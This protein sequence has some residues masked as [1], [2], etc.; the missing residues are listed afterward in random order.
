MKKILWLVSV[1]IVLCSGNAQSLTLD[2]TKKDAS[3][4]TINYNNQVKS[5]MNLAS[6]DHEK[7]LA[8]FGLIAATNNLQ[9]KQLA[10]ENF[11][12]DMTKY[13]FLTGDS[14]DTVNPKLW[15]HAKINMNI[16][17][18]K[19]TEN[20]YQVRGFDIANITFIIG[21]S[22][23]IIIDPLTAQETA[24]AALDFVNEKLGARPVAAVI[25][26]HSHTDHYGGINGVATA[27]TKIYAPDGFMDAVC[28]ENLFAGV[29]MLR[30]TFF[31]YGTILERGI[32]GH[33]DS[34]LGK[35][36]AV[37]K[38]SLRA[39]DFI[40]TNYM[41]TSQVD[42]V[43]M[44][45]QLTLGT[46]APSEMNVYIPS[47]K[48]LCIAEN[49][50]ATLHNLYTLRGAEVRDPEKW[51]HYL[52]EAIKYFGHEATSI[53]STHNWPRFGNSEVVSFMQ[54]Q[55][56]CY[57]YIKDQTLRLMSLGYT[58]N[59]VGR[60]ISLPKALSDCFFNGEFYGTVS[61]NA[62]AVYQKYLGWY[63]SNP[64]NLNKLLPK[65]S[66]VKYVEYMGGPEKI[67]AAAKIDFDN[68]EYQWVAEVTKQII[69][70]DPDNETAKLLCADALEQLGYI[71]ESGPWRNEYLHAA[72]ELRHGVKIPDTGVTMNEDVLSALSERHF[73]TML[74]IR[75]NGTRAA[76]ENVIFKIKSDTI[77]LKLHLRNSILAFLN[78]STNEASYT[79]TMDKTSF[80]NLVSG[81]RGTLS[82]SVVPSSKT[83]DFENFLDMLDVPNNRFNIM[84][85][86]EEVIPEP[87]SSVILFFSLLVLA[88]R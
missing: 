78:N 56:D 16:G 79:A 68:G 55:R 30:R 35:Y 57:Q 4:Y 67:L 19:I 6:I 44:I 84:T 49:C 75:L 11:A 88:R 76:D 39:P 3:I 2:K 72:D 14:P 66:A 53:F 73:A 17:L 21:N 81:A 23:W 32:K 62:K 85:P 63:D 22:G 10:T 65:D 13:S 64:V 51:A 9:I 80:Y 47:E 18:Y 40:I 52:D 83:T 87:S 31:M 8:G 82:Y 12:W 74:A 33:V 60:M 24:K 37:G 36:P 34:G 54:A 25:Y 42:G 46:E 59:E 61:H 29:A 45:F 86:V 43:E 50:N 70:A 28:S 15:E 38:G 20:I 7:I 58:I 5:N 1:I 48:S 77:E 71:S 26:T 69:Y 27:G 41:Q